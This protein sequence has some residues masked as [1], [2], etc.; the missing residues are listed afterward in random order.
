MAHRLAVAAGLVAAAAAGSAAEFRLEVGESV[1]P[2]DFEA[3][4]RAARAHRRE[5]PDDTIVI[6]LPA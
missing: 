1:A 2:V 5:H 3:T 4:L 6:A